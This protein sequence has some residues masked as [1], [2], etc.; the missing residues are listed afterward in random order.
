MWNPKEPKAQ[1]GE[2]NKE[3]EREHQRP[4]KGMGMNETSKDPDGQNKC[5]IGLE[6]G[7]GAERAKG[8]VA[9]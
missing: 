8:A 5:T 3:E 6:A 1:K 9:K 4:K 7:E 2:E